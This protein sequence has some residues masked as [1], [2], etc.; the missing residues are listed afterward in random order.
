LKR[1]TPRNDEGRPTAK[2]FQSLTSNVGY[3]KLKEHLGAVV[4]LMRVSNTWEAFMR[5]LDRHY[6]RF[7]DTM[8]L[9]YDD[10]IGL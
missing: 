2:Y 3:P 7:G 10:G 9:P 5:L 1:V 6:P 4:A 8:Q